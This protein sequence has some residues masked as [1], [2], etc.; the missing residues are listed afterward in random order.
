MMRRALFV[1][2]TLSFVLGALVGPAAAGGAPAPGKAPA[3][4]SFT[5]TA[6]YCADAEEMAFLKLINDYRQQNGRAPLTL[7]QTL[8]AASD[9]HSVSM[10]NYNYFNH[11]L[12]PEGIGWSQNMTNHGYTYST[13]RGENIA[14]GNATASA[15]FTQWKNSPDHNTN[16]LNANFKAIGIGRAYNS[17]STYDW[18]W[19]TNFGGYVDGAAAQ[20]GGTTPSPS[21]SPTPAPTGSRLTISASGRTSNSNSSGYAWD[22]NTSTSWYTTVTTTPSSAYIYFDLGAVRSIGTIKWMFGQSG[23]ADAMKIQVS[24][25]RAAWTTI[26]NGGNASANTWQTLTYRVSARYVRFYFTNPNGDARLGYVS[27]VQFYS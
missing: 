20:C 1:V 6:S 12:T 27:E 10:A 25:D 23:W 5:T 9:H 15:T 7:T 8:G 21:P 3:A 14:A 17:A 22:N 16:M 19:T 11:F 4:S 13:Y 24:N 2:L 18:Y 26:A